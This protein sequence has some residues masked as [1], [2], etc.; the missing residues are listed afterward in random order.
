MTDPLAHPPYKTTP[1]FDETS[2]PQGLRGAHSTKAGVWGRLV[3]TEGEVRLIFHDPRREVLV[4]PG[5]PA[6]IA[7]EAVHHVETTGPMTMRVEFHRH[8]SSTG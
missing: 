3:V 5:N 8:E 6:I 1:W 7:P 2:L 4:T